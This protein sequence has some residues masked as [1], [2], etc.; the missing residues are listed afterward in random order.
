MDPLQ[1]L[2]QDTNFFN[3]VVLR[4]S[5]CSFKDNCVSMS[6]NKEREEIKGENVY[7]LRYA[8]TPK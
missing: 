4:S 5:I 1:T 3:H 6:Q 8:I 7:T 2:I